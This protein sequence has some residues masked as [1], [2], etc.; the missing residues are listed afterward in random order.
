MIEGGEIVLYFLG[1]DIL[2]R[3]FEQSDVEHLE[4]ALLADA[5]GAEFDCADCWQDADEEM[6]PP[7][8]I[9]LTEIVYCFGERLLERF[10]EL[11]TDTGKDAKSRPAGGLINL[12]QLEMMIVNEAGKSELS[13]CVVTEAFNLPDQ[14]IAVMEIGSEVVEDMFLG[15]FFHED[16][17]SGGQ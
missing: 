16:R 6:D 4:H 3:P 14:G 13:A 2:H 10:V 12:A 1:V 7:G 17:A 8:G 9:D 5:E 15:Y 11:E